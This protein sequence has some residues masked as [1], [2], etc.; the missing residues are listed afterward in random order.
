MPHDVDQFTTEVQRKIPPE[1]WKQIANPNRKTEDAWDARIR[2]V[3]DRDE[4]QAEMDSLSE[5]FAEQAKSSILDNHGFVPAH[6]HPLS[7]LT[8]MFLHTGW[9]HLIGNMW[10]LW[11]AGFVL[12]DKWGRLMV[13]Y[14]RRDSKQSRRKITSRVGLGRKAS[15][16]T[17][18]TNWNRNS[19][20]RL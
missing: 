10:F 15:A 20:S 13:V 9:I 19:R 17:Y 14:G 16:V 12:E 5:R 2:T 4:L 18:C 8:S 6:S 7:F 3:T 11:L 1:L